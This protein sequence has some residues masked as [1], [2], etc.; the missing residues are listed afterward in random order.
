MKRLL[1]AV[2]GIAILTGCIKREHIVKST[3]AAFSY[4]VDEKNI[5]GMHFDAYDAYE[6]YRFI[7]T[8]TAEK[9]TRKFSPKGEIIGDIDICSYIYSYPT[10]TIT[11]KNYDG[12]DKTVTG[13]FLDYDT[14]R[15]GKEEYI[16][17]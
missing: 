8:G 12:K 7:D 4:H 9:S 5:A 13:Q 17:Q 6:V 2:L 15:I 14:F 10:I 16:R 3:F 11:Y 1:L